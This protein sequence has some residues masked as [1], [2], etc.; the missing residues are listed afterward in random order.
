MNIHIRPDGPASYFN[1]I[2]DLASS[3]PII[4]LFCSGSYSVSKRLMQK[5]F[6][7]AQQLDSILAIGFRTPLPNDRYKRSFWHCPYVFQGPD[8]L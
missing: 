8:N 5:M 6:A 1:K 2:A 4:Q 3:R 7:Q